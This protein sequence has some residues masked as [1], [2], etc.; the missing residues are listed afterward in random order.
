MGR[1][2]N[3]HSSGAICSNL[4]GFGTTRAAALCGGWSL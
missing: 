3:F 2:C 4:E 1:Q